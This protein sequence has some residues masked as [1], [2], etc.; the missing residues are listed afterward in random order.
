[1]PGHPGQSMRLT[2]TGDCR[3][4]EVTGIFDSSLFI[5]T[6]ISRRS[7]VRALVWCTY[8]R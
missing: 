5:L 6:G 7:R 3:F 2:L 8:Y 1:V 4:L